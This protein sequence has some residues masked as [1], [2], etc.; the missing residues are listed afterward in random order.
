[1]TVMEKG[2]TVVLSPDPGGPWTAVCPAMP[3]AIAEAD[4]REQLLAVMADVM[5]SWLAIAS[6]D[7]YGAL[8]ETPELVA[9]KVAEVLADRAAEGWDLVV[10][11]TLLGPRA[12][13]AA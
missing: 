6:G 13:V 3:G 2:Y 12:A 1:M 4:S 9:A 8:S 10:E 5:V 11:T 7:G